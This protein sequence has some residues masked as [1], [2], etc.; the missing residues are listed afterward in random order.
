MAT[1]YEVA[2]YLVYLMNGVCDDLSNM[3]LNKLLYYAQGHH[4]QKTGRVLFSDKIE[5]WDHGPIVDDVYQR[6]KKYGDA[7][8]P[9]WDSNILDRLS[10][11]EQ[12]CLMDIARTYSRFTASALRNMTHKPNGPWDKVYEHGKYHTEIP[13]SLITDYFDKKIPP[14][15]PVEL[16]LSSDSFIGYRDSDGYLVLPGDWDDETV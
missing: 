12:D 9:T 2:N 15:K 6:Y 7:P 3:K 11:E 8:I 4:L 14:I 5:A 16:D 1:A 13:V 10:E